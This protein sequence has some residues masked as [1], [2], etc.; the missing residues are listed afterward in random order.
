MSDLTPAQRRILAVLARH[1][2]GQP[3]TA[4][5]ISASAYGHH[6]GALVASKVVQSLER[7]GLAEKFN[8]AHGWSWRIT[9]EGLEAHE[10]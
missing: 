10:Q 6:D 7:A 5:A 2:E 9:P 4:E 8:F 1:A 3:L